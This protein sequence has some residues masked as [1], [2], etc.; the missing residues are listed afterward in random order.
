MAI[1][2]GF[3]PHDPIY[4]YRSSAHADGLA[5]PALSW[6]LVGTSTDPNSG[7]DAHQSLHFL[8]EGNI[9]GDLY[10]TGAR[11]HAEVGP[12]FEDRDRIDLYHVTSDTPYFEPGEQIDLT[13]RYNSR[14]LTP[15][16]STGGALLASLAAATGFHETPSGELLFYATLHDNDGPGGTATAGEWRHINLVRDDSPTLR[17]TAVV[18]GPYE[19]DEGSSVTLT[20]SA[21]PAVTKA[22]IQL[23]HEI[24]FGGTDFSTFYPVV[25]YD[26]RDRDD[27]DD[28][29][30][31]E[32]QVFPFFTH[33]DKARSW[34]W[35]AP[36]GCSIQ[37]LDHDRGTLDEAKTLAGTGSQQGDPDLRAVPNDGGTDDIDQ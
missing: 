14:R 3:E 7:D 4:F 36:V 11:G 30:A 13:V 28:F 23:F 21:R 31:L 35:F 25:D 24:N 10:L 6:E 27:F 33:A 37:A 9:N 18:D 29:R 34:K 15:R 8:R 26:D 2:G 1:I 19:V 32:L 20:G 17:P 5:N 16:P 12:F 22:A